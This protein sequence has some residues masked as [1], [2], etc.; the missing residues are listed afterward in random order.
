MSAPFQPGN[1]VLC[2]DDRPGKVKR[3]L[4][5]E[6]EVVASQLRRGS[7]YRVSK[8][9]PAPNGKVGVFIEGIPPLVAWDGELPF[10]SD[11]FRK[12]DDEVTEDF[13]QQLRS[14]K[15]PKPTLNPKRHSRE[16]VA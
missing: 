2:V 15:S 3:T 9:G 6:C 1:V 7:I 13:R 11:R 5:G 16:R 4:L 10:R 14:L 12:I 8:V